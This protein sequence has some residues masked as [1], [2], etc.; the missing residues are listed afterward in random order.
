MSERVGHQWTLRERP[1]LGGGH[2]WFGTNLR[3]K[4]WVGP[5]M[6]HMCNTSNLSY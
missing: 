6:Q 5:S 3:S 2:S 1:V 4:F